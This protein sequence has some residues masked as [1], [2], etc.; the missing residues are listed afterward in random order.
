MGF[1]GYTPKHRTQQGKVELYDDAP[2]QFLRVAVDTIH[3]RGDIGYWNTRWVE[4]EAQLHKCPHPLRPLGKFIPETVERD[5][6]TVPGITYGQVGKREYPPAGTTIQQVNGT[7]KL[8]LPGTRRNEER[9]GV[10]YLQVRNLRRTGI[11]PYETPA[12]KRFIEAG[13]HNDLA[14]SRLAVGDLLMVNSG[15]GSLGRCTV[16]TDQFPFGQ[17]NISQDITRIVLQGITPEW[18]AVYLQTEWGAHQIVRY[19]SGVSGQIKIDF[20]ELRRIEVAKPPVA[21]Q[22]EFRQNYRLMTEYHI[23]MLEARKSGGSKEQDYYQLVALGMLEALINQAELAVRDKKYR[24]IPL[25]PNGLPESLTKLLEDEYARIGKMV[26]QAD[27]RPRHREF[28]ARPLGIPLERDPQIA[29][30]VERLMRWVQGFMEF[31]NA[32]S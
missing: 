11:D 31:R 3:K 15:I 20:G 12:E 29:Q 7:V 27:I 14:R 18:V 26:E 19:A 28:Q 1:A 6:A 10:L 23:R 5:G 22:R 2:V 32:S 16:L 4:L 24:P 25:V 13:S 17:I 30:E 8:L 21:V 9:E